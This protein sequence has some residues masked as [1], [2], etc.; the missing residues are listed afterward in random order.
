MQNHGEEEAL[1]MERA[2][3][4]LIPLT[5]QVEDND[6]CTKTKTAEKRTGTQETGKEKNCHHPRRP[7]ETAENKNGTHRYDAERE[8]WKCTQCDENPPRKPPGRITFG[9]TRE[10][11]R[12]K[13]IAQ[14]ILVTKENNEAGIRALLEYSNEMRGATKTTSKTKSTMEKAK[15]TW[16]TR[17]GSREAQSQS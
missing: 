12:T 6:K 5:A 16:R 7:R 13:Q 15:K 4:G 3:W 1:E 10:D 8:E 2:S 9:T 11:E 14:E 17:G